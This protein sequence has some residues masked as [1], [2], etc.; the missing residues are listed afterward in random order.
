MAISVNRLLRIGLLCLGASDRHVSRSVPY[1]KRVVRF[2]S[3][4]GQLP[5]VYARLWSELRDIDTERNMAKY[6]MCLYW[7]KNYD[8]ESV[9]AV[10][11]DLGE[12]TVR[13]WLW[14]YAEAIALL[15][16]NK[17]KMP[18]HFHADISY[19]MV[20]DG[21][22][23]TCYE[24]MDEYYPMD[25]G[26]FGHKHNTASLAYQ[27]AVSTFEQQIYSVDGPY[28]AGENNDMKMFKKSGLQEKLVSMGKF[29]VADGG[30]ED[31]KGGGVAV[32][33]R[34]YHSKL[35]NMYFR[36]CRA[37]VER[38][39]GYFKN[40]KILSTTFRIRKDRLKKHKMVFDAIAVIVQIAIE[41][42]N[43]L[44]NP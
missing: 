8:T 7:F 27:V 20:V 39:M 13:L 23:A 26:Y 38:L 5:S 19:P 21:I 28:P 15:K 34:K 32:P 25:T 44:F 33:N 37:R 42:E 36:R 3:C 18:D 40:F 14:Y 31:I 4:F 30:Y 2:K 6:F 12:E 11:F 22:H 43:P 17:I 35:T 16:E 24:P 10:R 41:T 29:A 1:A 9:L